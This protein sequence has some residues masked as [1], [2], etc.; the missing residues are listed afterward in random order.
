M[1]KFS[2][3]LSAAVLTAVAS[4]VSAAG[5]LKNASVTGENSRVALQAKDLHKRSF[6]KVETL[7]PEFTAN[8]MKA[9]KAASKVKA[10]APVTQEPVTEVP[11]GTVSNWSR[12]CGGYLVFFGYVLYGED[13]GGV[14]KMV[15]AGDNTVWL[16]N[17]LSQF[18]I[19]AWVKGVKDADGNISIASGQAV[20]QE[21]EE[22]ET[23]T[24]YMCPL[25]YKED[26]EGGWFYP[27]DA[28]YKLVLK[29]GAYQAA[30]PEVV[31][32]ICYYGDGEMS[33]VG[34][35]DDNVVI[36]AVTGEA[37]ELPAGLTSEKWAV[38]NGSEGYFANVAVD[39]ANGKLY[40]GGLNQSVPD[41][42]VVGDIKGETVVF[43]GAQFLG[44]D[45]SKHW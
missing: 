24:Y 21:F 11:S 20:Y 38:T 29:D 8:P 30:D 23:Y 35:G 5:L 16:N 17:P 26:E 34:Y 44:E 6:K 14:V 33:W 37:L 2:V 3:L 13:A 28:D 36:N 1:K 15:D 32:G 42:Y 45:A 12:D 39:N 40:V 31:F 19:D 43:A 25:E 27:T 22:G 4:P 10:V 9:R 41:S 7:N 18:P